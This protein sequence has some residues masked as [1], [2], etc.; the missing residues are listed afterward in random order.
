MPRR[1]YHIGELV[2]SYQNPTQKF[3]VSII[4]EGKDGFPNKYKLSLRDKD[5]FSKSSNWIDEKSLYKTKKKGDIKKK[6]N[7]KKKVTKPTIAYIKSSTLTDSPY[8]FEMVKA[9]QLKK[10]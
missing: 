7:M 5:G 4:R 2:Y 10:K 1:K 8:F 3:G 6:G 9:Y